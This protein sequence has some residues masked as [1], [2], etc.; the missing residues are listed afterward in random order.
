MK[1]IFDFFELLGNGKALL[2]FLGSKNAKHYRI[3][4]KEKSWFERLGINRIVPSIPNIVLKRGLLSFK[5]VFTMSEGRYYHFAIKGWV[6]SIG[7]NSLHRVSK[8]GAAFLVRQSNVHDV[9]KELMGVTY[10]VEEK[11]ESD[12]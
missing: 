4:V 12:K 2:Y 9:L 3:F 7:G 11:K 5:M 6:Y 8:G 1:Y 10:K